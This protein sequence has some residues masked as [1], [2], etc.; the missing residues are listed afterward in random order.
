MIKAIRILTQVAFTGVRI[1]GRA[2]VD[3][4]K[5][6]STIISYCNVDPFMNKESHLYVLCNK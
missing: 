5:V 2:F 1:V 3:A 6:A 4:Y